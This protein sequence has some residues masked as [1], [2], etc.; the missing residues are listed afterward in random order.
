M[1]FRAKKRYRPG[2]D[3]PPPSILDKLVRI[4]GIAAILGVVTGWFRRRA[5]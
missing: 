1:W 2:I 4:T 3:D 5:K